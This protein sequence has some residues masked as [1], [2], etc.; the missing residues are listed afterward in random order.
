MFFI[1][2]WSLKICC[3]GTIAPSCPPLNAALVRPRLVHADLNIIYNLLYAPALGTSKTPKWRRALGPCVPERRP[4]A[5]S[6]VWKTIQ[7]NAVWTA[8]GTSD[9]RFC[10][11][12]RHRPTSSSLSP[13]VGP[14]RFYS[15][16]ATVSRLSSL[17]T[18]P[19]KSN[20]LEFALHILKQLSVRTV[21]P[22]PIGYSINV[23]RNYCTYE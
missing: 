1:Y 2:C 15:S 8:H 18:C 21:R 22:V 19:L 10:R 12:R 14:C 13:S 6:T 17:R 5:L 9:R 23:Q 16:R 20:L 3:H 7:N 11:C 4:G